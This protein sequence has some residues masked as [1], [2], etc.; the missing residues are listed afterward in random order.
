MKKE[1]T[2]LVILAAI[3]AVVFFA[4]PGSN[5]PGEPQATEPTPKVEIQESSTLET[6]EQTTTVDTADAPSTAP[7]T[8]EPT[9][10]FVDSISIEKIEQSVVNPLANITSPAQAEANSESTELKGIPAEAWSNAGTGDAIA[11][12]ETLLWRG[13]S[14]DLPFAEKMVRWMESDSASELT[15]IEATKSQLVER[16]TE[17]IKNLDTF[18]VIVNEQLDDSTRRV[19]VGFETPNGPEARGITFIKEGEDWFPV[20][21]LSAASESWDH[22][23]FEGAP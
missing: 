23:S 11:S 1:T 22:T 17:W 19:V 3:G 16:T 10:T 9:E 14:Q 18:D 21:H 15:D 7:P 12:L 13:K 20:M 4:L 2:I 8:I 6:V 5:R